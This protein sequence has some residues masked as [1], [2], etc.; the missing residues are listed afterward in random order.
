MAML[1]TLQADSAKK[2]YSRAYHKAVEEARKKG[3]DKAECSRLGREA[4]NTA[5]DAWYMEQ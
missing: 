2:V 5:R 1:V 4:G 3:L